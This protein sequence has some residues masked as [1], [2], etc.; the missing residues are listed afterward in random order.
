MSTKEAYKQKIEAELE[1]VQAKLAE[2]KAEAKSAGADVQIKYSEQ[3]NK[4]ERMTDATKEKLKEL[5]A[6]SEAS[7]EQLKQ[8]VESAWDTLSN[9]VQDTVSKFKK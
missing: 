5:D 7:W 6:A 8:G 9:A 2:L 1:L 3:V 4:L